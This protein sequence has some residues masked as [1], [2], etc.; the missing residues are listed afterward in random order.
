MVSKKH[1]FLVKLVRL[2]VGYAVASLQAVVEAGTK[3]SD[4]IGF[5]YSFRFIKGHV[6]PTQNLQIKCRVQLTFLDSKVTV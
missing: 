6:L 5:R 3:Y 1:L 4:G 2:E